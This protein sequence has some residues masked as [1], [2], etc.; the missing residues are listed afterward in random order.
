MAGLFTAAVIL[1]EW[2][3]SESW[4]QFAVNRLN[5]ELDQQVYPD[6][7]QKELTAGYHA[8]V[9]RNYLAVV[10]TS[11]LNGLSLPKDLTAK[12][13][14]MFEFCMALIMP[15]GSMPLFSDAWSWQIRSNSASA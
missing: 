12:L 5:E 7:A 4:R 13:E 15:D 8:V 3:E 11:R 9:L 1:P 14:K 6:G 10:G 2:N